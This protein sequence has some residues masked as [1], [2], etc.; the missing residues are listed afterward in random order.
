MKKILLGMTLLSTVAMGAEGTNLYLRAGS[1]LNEKFDVISSTPTE[2]LNEKKSHE[3]GYEIGVEAT[4]EVFPNFE[5]GLGV[6]YQDH[7]K[8][9]NKSYK[10]GNVLT[11]HKIPEMR[12][13]PLYVTAKYNIPVNSS[14]KPYLKADLGYSFNRTNGK[15]KLTQS[16]EPK[17]DG[18]YNTDIKNGVYFGIGGGFEYNNITMD[19][20]YKINKAE[21]EYGK[22]GTMIKK[23][24]DYSRI[25]LSGGYKFNF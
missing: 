22:Y 8:P 19:L 13:M 16:N 23:D 20:M 12:S 15:Y 25:T 9:K 14:I 24:L 17:L 1:D 5:L 18:V 6:S 4:R 2:N 3:I 7:S 11:V 10:E 21:F